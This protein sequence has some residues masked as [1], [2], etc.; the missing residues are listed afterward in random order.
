M[1][2]DVRGFTYALETLRSRQR[3]QLEALQVKLGAANRAIAD[4]GG[5]LAQQE[6]D[7]RAQLANASDAVT[8]RMDPVVHRRNLHW[9]AQLR[10]QIAQ[11][12]A[13]LDE[14][15]EGRA[16]LRADCLAR[17]NKLDVIER[18]REEC[19]AQYAQA[20]ENRLA[21]AADGAWLVRRQSI[22]R[23]EDR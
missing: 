21:A 18:H 9:L 23:V 14:M 3:W 1:S 4:A 6:A 5:R 19:L 15:R 11:A 2:T 7:L 20:H 8:Q 16:S 13:R 17:Q 22:A 12:Q 10:E